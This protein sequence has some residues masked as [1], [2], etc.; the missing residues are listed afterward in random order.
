MASGEW[1]VVV[2]LPPTTFARDGHFRKSELFSRDF[3]IAKYIFSKSGGGLTNFFIVLALEQRHLH[4]RERLERVIFQNSNLGFLRNR[5]GGFLLTR[6]RPVESF[7]LTFISIGYNINNHLSG[8][9]EPEESG[10]N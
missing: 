2:G 6:K 8:K 9:V 7:N 4:R 1:P 10:K 3:C 5:N